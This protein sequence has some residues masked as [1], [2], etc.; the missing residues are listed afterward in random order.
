LIFCF[1]LFCF[2]LFCFYFPF[3]KPESNEL[4]IENDPVVR[5]RRIDL[6]SRFVQPRGLKEANLL[7]AELHNEGILDGQA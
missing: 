7:R 6:V 2:V 5:R 1:V 4:I 3:W